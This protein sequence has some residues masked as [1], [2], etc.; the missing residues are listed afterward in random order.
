MD[1]AQRVWAEKGV[2]MI[3]GYV[4]RGHAVFQLH[5]NI[6]SDTFF[7]DPPVFFP[8]LGGVLRGTRGLTHYAVV[9]HH[10]YGEPMGKNGG[11]GGGVRAEAA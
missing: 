5:V 4:R 3:Q 1:C 7:A 9:L 2:L 8:C 6:A 11:A 10:F